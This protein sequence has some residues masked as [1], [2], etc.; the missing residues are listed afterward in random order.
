MASGIEQSWSRKRHSEGKLG[1][2]NDNSIDVPGLV[3]SGR[4][5]FRRLQEFKNAGV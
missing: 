1:K 3:L 5:Q 4:L 2:A